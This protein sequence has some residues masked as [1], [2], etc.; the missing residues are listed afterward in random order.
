ML[1]LMLMQPQSDPPPPPPPPLLLHTGGD[2][3]FK[4]M[5]LMWGMEVL[6]QMGGVVL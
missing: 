1:N 3:I 6:L 5:A 2:E 4:K